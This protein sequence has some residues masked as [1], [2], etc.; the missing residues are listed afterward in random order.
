[1]QARLGWTAALL[2]LGACV[3]PSEAPPPPAPAPASTPTPPPAPPPLEWQD[4]P[5]SPGDWSYAERVARFGAAVALRCD[6]GSRRVTIELP[7]ATAGPLIVR[8]SYGD[9]SRAASAGTDALIVEL[10]AGDPVLDQIAYSRGR[11]MLAAGG[12]ELILPAWAEVARVVE[13]CR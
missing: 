4:R 9:T 3:R 1:V 7:G 5:Y 10:P 6:P 8:T 11:F 12:R 2:A 13:D